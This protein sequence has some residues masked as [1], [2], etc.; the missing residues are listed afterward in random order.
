MSVLNVL[1][2]RGGGAE[3][4][5]DCLEGLDGYTQ[6]RRPLSSTRSP[7]AAGPSIIARWP[8]V[9]LAARRADLLQ[10]H[11]DVASILSLALLRARPS[12]AVTHGLHLLR[13]AQGTPLR[14]VQ[15]AMAAVVAA[16]DLTVCNSNGER[17]GRASHPRAAARAAGGR[18]Q[19][20]SAAERGVSARRRR[21]QSRAGR[22]PHAVVAL[23]LGHS[24]SARTRS[25]P[26]APWRA[27]T[28]RARR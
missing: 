1:P 17:E 12:V 22:H 14:A 16:A 24:R 2:H 6:L 23:Y 4:F 5:I 27:R 7:L 9:A 8:A 3:T 11:G 20:G 19:H 25:P 10:T 13:R 26:S 28:P 21:G 15:Q 18:P